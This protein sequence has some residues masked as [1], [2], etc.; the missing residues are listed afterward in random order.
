MD[1][2][3]D[4][5]V[6]LVTG[7]V[8]GVGAGISRAFLGAGATVVTCARRP[9]DEPVEVDGRAAEFIAC[10]VRDPEQVQAMID[11]IVATHGRLDTVV[12]NA[13][14]APFALAADASPRF[15][16]KIVEL[17]LLSPL[18]VAQ[19]AN[20]VMQRQETGGSIVN[21]SSVSGARPSPGTAA[22][23]AAKAGIDSLSTS[24]AVE[25]A[26]RVRVNSVVVGLVETEQSH[27]HYGGPDGLAAVGA[28]VPLGRMARPEDI[29]NC[30]TFLASPLASYVS[31]STLTVHGGGER[32]AFLAA[33]DTEEN[34]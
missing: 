1:L 25:W 20:A 16:S 22:Y 4:G 31:G 29:G 7:G 24:L 14:G 2:G 6:V 23:G 27:L 28:T 32:P 5:N 3:L 19:T 21:I 11:S 15:H 18:L 26:P 13:G 33:A 12:N 9:G 17:N 8:R 34:K 10:D 30:A